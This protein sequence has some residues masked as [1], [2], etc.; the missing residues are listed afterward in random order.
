MRTTVNLDDDL[1][2]VARGLASSSG[3]SLG[4]VLSRLIRNGMTR[5]A[6][7]IGTGG[8]PTFDVPTDA[9]I[10]PGTRA[11]ELLADEGLP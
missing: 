2:E 10:I 11:P 1:L 4:T 3:D 9:P 7:A 6:P 5:R 8:L